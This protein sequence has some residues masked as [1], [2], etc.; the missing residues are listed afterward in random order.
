MN[1][2]TLDDLA[3]ILGHSDTK[4]ARRYRHFTTDFMKKQSERVQLSAPMKD[5]GERLLPEKT[6]DKFK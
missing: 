4:M 2:G 6:T 1:G 5:V 3:E